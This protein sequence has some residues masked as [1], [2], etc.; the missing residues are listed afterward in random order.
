MPDTR[1]EAGLPKPGTAATPRDG[2]RGARASLVLAG[3]RQRLAV[4]SVLAA[5]LWVGVLWA[6]G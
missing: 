6:I 4:L 5:A 1:A 3:A 2:R